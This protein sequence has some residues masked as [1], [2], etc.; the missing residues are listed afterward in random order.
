MVLFKNI[1]VKVCSKVFDLACLYKRGYLSS[2]DVP[3]KL[4]WTC[5]ECVS[6]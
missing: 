2:M 3:L 5:S 1:F 4:E 6:I